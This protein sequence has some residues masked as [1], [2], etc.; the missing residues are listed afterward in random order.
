MENIVCDKL[1]YQTGTNLLN[2]EVLVHI[3]A[4]RLAVLGFLTVVLCPSRQM[5]K[6]CHNSF[7]VNPSSFSAM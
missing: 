1:K 6:L 3:L 2:W 5:L 4:K 7:H